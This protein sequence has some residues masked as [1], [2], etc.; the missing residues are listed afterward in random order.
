VLDRFLGYLRVALVAALGALGFAAVA[1]G[2]LSLLTPPKTEPVLHC[3]PTVLMLALDKSNSM[4]EEGKVDKLTPVQDAVRRFVAK[5]KEDSCLSEKRY[6]LV[7]FT[8]Q[9]SLD[10]PPTTD[11]HLIETA[12]NNIVLGPFTTIETGLT[13][14]AQTLQ[15]ADFGS[16][17]KVIF[18]LTDA[19]NYSSD[20]SSSG[21]NLKQALTDAKNSGIDV[22]A[23]V[24]DDQG[25]QYGVLQEV[26]GA[27]KVTKTEEA[28]MGESFFEQAE[29]IVALSA[30]IIN[31]ERK[32]A[33]WQSYLYTGLW[34]GLVTAGITFAL[35]I[36]LN[37]FNKRKRFLSLKEGLAILLSL[38]LG[39][40]IGVLLQYV[41]SLESVT[42]A[43][44]GEGNF[45]TKHAMDVIIWSLIGLL[46]AAGLAGF[47]ILPNLKFLSAVGFGLL[48]G[49]V[50]GL[51][52][53]LAVEFLPTPLLA[54][55][56][57]ATALGLSL[58]FAV[59]L[60]SEAGT[61]YPLWLRVYYTSDKVYRYHPLGSTPLTLGSGSEA[62]IYVQ[63]D[64][65]K[66]W[67]FWIDNGKVMINNLVANKPRAVSF[68]EALERGTI[69][70]KGMIL[71]I[72]SD[73]GPE[74]GKS[75]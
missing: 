35:L 48:G 75:Q 19:E 64:Y 32:L 20:G 5:A 52:Y 36:Y 15:G 8:N 38:L 41:F 45:F 10:I 26:L 53:S 2:V 50:A 23:V 33:P 58:G 34:T 71:K 3:Q 28:S 54:S 74:K 21:D 17:N 37:I 44:T 31:P 6:G 13:T 73:I 69:E 9:A 56:L 4:R 42:T 11:L 12:V 43:L 14:A 39:L 29:E 25:P 16:W 46:L 60:L 63:G 72:V 68:K 61:Q 55:L 24:T 51:L 59:N 67:Q 70:L 22:R 1:Q 66:L 47:K 30:S 57:G 49:V 7:T 65:E 27:D 62:D 18:L 40:G